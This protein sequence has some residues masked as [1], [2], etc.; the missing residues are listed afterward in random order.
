MR[1]SPYCIGRDKDLM[2]VSGLANS[3]NQL[4][5]RCRPGVGWRTLI[6][7]Q[8]PRCNPRHRTGRQGRQC[9]SAGKYTCCQAWRLW[10]DSW[11]PHGR[12]RK[13]ISPYYPDCHT[14][15]WHVYT[16]IN[17]IKINVIFLREGWDGKMVQWLIALAVP[18]EDQVPARH[19]HGGSQS[20]GTTVPEDHT[21]FSVLC[22]HQGCT[23]CTEVHGVA[24]LFVWKQSLLLPRLWFLA[25][26]PHQVDYKSPVTQS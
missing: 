1:S 12:T 2:I 8:G 17:K 9:V 15:T 11:V 13:P 14:Y 10:F 20:P 3:Y 7:M 23:W 22:R 4:W 5:E 21:L 18:P 16:H 25:S 6:S 19:P 26:A 24:W